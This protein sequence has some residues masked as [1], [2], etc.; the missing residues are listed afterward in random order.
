MTGS[1]YEATRPTSWPRSRL[2]CPSS[3]AGNSAFG[4]L[5]GY[6]SGRNQ[7]QTSVAMTAPVI[8]ATAQ[9][10]CYSV[11]F[12]LPT[13]MTARTAPEPTN[14]RVT[15]R[16]VPPSLGA[17][18]RYSGRW[19][20]TSFESHCTGLLAGIEVEGFTVVGTPRFARFDPPYKPW[21]LRRNEVIVD[22]LQ[23]SGTPH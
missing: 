13:S 19:P 2:G 1:R 15:I 14:P 18:T 4:F 10:G 22:V 12:V 9:E 5:F 3:K 20:Q 17:A 11:A 6:I 23:D 16:R 8:Q 21:F 7:S